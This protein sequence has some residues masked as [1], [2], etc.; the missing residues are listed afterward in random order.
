MKSTW[1]I[2][3]QQVTE[4]LSAADNYCTLATYVANSK[5]T[6]PFFGGTVVEVYNYANEQSVNGKNENSE[7]MVLC[8]RVPD[9][10]QPAK[11]LVAPCFLPN[12]LAG[13]YWVVAAGPSQ[14]NYE[15][16]I[17]SGGQ[18]TVAG[19]DGGCTTKTTG[20]NGAGFWLFTRTQVASTATIA[21][22]RS[23]AQKAGFSLD[24][25]NPV[26]QSGCSYSGALLKN[27]GAELST[28]PPQES[29]VQQAG[30]KIHAEGQHISDE[31]KKVFVAQHSSAA[32]TGDANSGTA[33]I[34]AV[35]ACAGAA[36]TAFGAAIMFRRSQQQH[37]Q[38][39]MMMTA[40]STDYS[41][42]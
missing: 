22:M 28:P 15:W 32:A 17:V 3:Q 29:L 14:D 8:A 36:L 24:K 9:N 41:A 34:A 1:Y 30:D 18:P 26:E 23:T 13:D 20:T 37:Q 2:Q 7:G 10:S 39:V 27:E 33:V 16:A 21:E 4:Y 5:K 25:L 42:L 12:V 35:S 6:V 38:Q 19:A 40:D 11:L 31:F